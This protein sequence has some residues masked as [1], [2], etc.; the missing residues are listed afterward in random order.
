MRASEFIGSLSAL[1]ARLDSVPTTENKLQT[2]A[3]W[4][5]AV[6]GLEHALLVDFR[7]GTVIAAG[8]AAA[9]PVESERILS[10]AGALPAA[11]ALL[12]G[13][14]ESTAALDPYLNGSREF[15]H[16]PLAAP[17]G[18]ALGS[19]LLVSKSPAEYFTGHKNEI[20]LVA[21]KLRDLLYIEQ[22]AVPPKPDYPRKA[23]SADGQPSAR[24]EIAMMKNF[25]DLMNFPMFIMALDGEMIAVNH[26]LLLKL[27]FESQAEFIRRCEIFRDVF[28]RG[29]LLK[30]LARDGGIRGK[31][32]SL[33]DAGS[34][35]VTL[36]LTAVRLESA[37]VGS[38]FDVSEFVRVT[39]D[40]R[41][42]LKM[43]E[44]LND[45]LISANLLL[46]KTKSSTIRSLARLAEFRDIG[47]GDHLKRICE[48]SRLIAQEILRRQPY[49]DYKM[50][51]EFP[52]EIFLASML[53]D[54]GKVAIPDTILL[55]QERLTE[56][57][58]TIMKKHT[59]YGWEILNQADCELG[60]QS[61]LTLASH[62]ALNHHERWDGSG[63][64]NGILS[65]GIPH[66]ARIGA[67]ADVY[68]ALT[69][70]RPYKTPWHHDDA[71]AEIK[72][73]A[74]VHFDPVIVDMLLGVEKKVLDI[75]RLFPK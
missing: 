62:I 53:H 73:K 71:V 75:H 36:N 22:L 42:S 55:K 52:D 41:E 40:L 39:E 54:I 45:K 4:L 48:Y 31:R 63:Y 72:A 51:P 10:L 50:R 68:D 44:F 34:E 17:D 57:E 1:V 6:H 16:F 12:P 49:P 61:F 19:L 3:E 65:E 20:R 2:L 66:C 43:Q 26:S 58:W 13:K 28:L 24:D 9:E 23:A 25:I 35:R 11:E 5:A 69:S 74:G 32:C 67:V 15:V 29:E 59:L 7:T 14:T 30:Q 33:V 8:R 21:A 27:K 60:E 70:A 38:L 18:R 46:H 47:T 56:D 64:P 37:V